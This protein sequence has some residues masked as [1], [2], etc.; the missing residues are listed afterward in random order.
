MSFY[1][2][3]INKRLTYRCHS[4]NFYITHTPFTLSNLSPINLVSIFRC[5]SPPINPWYVRCVDPSSLVLYWGVIT[6]KWLSCEVRSLNGVSKLVSDWDSL[7]I[8]DHLTNK[9]PSLCDK[10]CLEGGGVTPSPPLSLSLTQFS[11]PKCWSA[12]ITWTNTYLDFLVPLFSLRILLL[13]KD[14]W[15]S[16]RVRTVG[17]MCKWNP[18][19]CVRVQKLFTEVNVRV[20]KLFTEVKT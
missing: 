12:Y 17:G 6:S 18:T 14:V 11:L 13:V 4:Y 8:M 10:D 19:S 9:F 2:F 20:Q 3:I 1:R 5:S 15:M 16:I 7:W